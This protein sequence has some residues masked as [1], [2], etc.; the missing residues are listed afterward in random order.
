VSESREADDTSNKDSY[1]DCP[2]YV[3]IKALFVRARTGVMSTCDR[4]RLVRLSGDL[5]EST[6]DSANIYDYAS[7]P[8]EMILPK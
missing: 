5:D 8:N 4:Y 2:R 6:I 7:V 1:K 3:A